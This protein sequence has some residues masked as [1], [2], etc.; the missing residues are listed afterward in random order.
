MMSEPLSN[1][2]L[3][4]VIHSIKISREGDTEKNITVRVVSSAL[5]DIFSLLNPEVVFPPGESFTYLNVTISRLPRDQSSNNFNLSLLPYSRDVSQTDSS[6]LLG[7]KREVSVT[8]TKADTR[9]VLFPGLP[10]VKGSGSSHPL[11]CIAVSKLWMC[12]DCAF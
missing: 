11:K 1:C 2:S 7:D 6:F 12:S 5:S 10:V 4:K 3:D 8:V 9:G